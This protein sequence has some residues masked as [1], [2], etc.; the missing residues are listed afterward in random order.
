MIIVVQRRA[1][2]VKWDQRKSTWSRVIYNDRPFILNIY[3]KIFL[4]ETNHFVAFSLGDSSSNHTTLPG[5]N[6]SLNNTVKFVRVGK[7]I[8]IAIA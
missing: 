1:Y 4:I 3:E 6:P 7:L 8:L 5:I 2:N